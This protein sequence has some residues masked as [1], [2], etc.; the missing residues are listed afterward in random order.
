MELQD[1]LADVPVGETGV[2]HRNR[3]RT[4]WQAIDPV[5]AVRTGGRRAEDTNLRTIVGVDRPEDIDRYVRNRRGAVGARDDAGDAR[6]RVE[7]DRHTGRLARAHEIDRRCRRR[8][9]RVADGD[10]VAMPDRDVGRRELACALVVTSEAAAD[11]RRRPAR[12]MDRRPRRDSAEAADEQDVD[13]ARAVRR[14][15]DARATLQSDASSK[16]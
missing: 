14:Q 2:E 9:E 10:D 8:A 16:A 12:R 13:R 7:H 4:H 1:D 15:H 6:H 5:A 3:E 11:A